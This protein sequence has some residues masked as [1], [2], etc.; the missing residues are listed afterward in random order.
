MA[1]RGGI[2]NSGERKDSPELVFGRIALEPI[3]QP[4]G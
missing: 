3:R 2:V 4:P 1:F